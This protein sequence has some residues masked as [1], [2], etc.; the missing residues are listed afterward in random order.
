[1]LQGSKTR[2]AQPRERE[3]THAMHQSSVLLGLVA[4]LFYAVTAIL[5]ARAAMIA[6]SSADAAQ[7]H[8]RVWLVAVVLFVVCA[9]SRLFGLEEGLRLMLRGELREERIYDVRRE[10]QAAIASAIIIVAGLATFAGAA[11]VIASGVLRAG[12]RTRIALAA[13]CACAA[14]ALLIVIRIVSLHML[15]VLIYRGPRLNWIVDIGST[16]IVGTL[17]WLYVSRARHPKRRH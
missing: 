11:R 4:A 12:G 16:V 15:D 10:Y 6:R 13:G 3:F 1:M 14:M 17:A 9:L 8:Q 7:W 2:R 5:A